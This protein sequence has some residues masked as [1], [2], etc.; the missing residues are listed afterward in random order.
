MAVLLSNGTTEHRPNNLPGMTTRIAGTVQA[1]YADLFA[2]FGP[3][4]QDEAHPPGWVI[5]VDSPDGTASAVVG[6]YAD[7]PRARP[8]KHTTWQFRITARA[9]HE[10]ASLRLHDLLTAEPPAPARTSTADPVADLR[11][12]ADAIREDHP[13]IAGAGRF[14]E[15]IASMFGRAAETAGSTP[16]KLR[17]R[18]LTAWNQTVSTARS[19]LDNG[20]FDVV[21]RA[22][23]R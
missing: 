21:A 5:R 4:D 20:P 2:L 7:D 23:R 6:I 14:W 16:E 17:G 12:A 8:Y 18:D 3:D 13:A 10:W 15:G 19:Y 1:S 11:A 22:G 9:G